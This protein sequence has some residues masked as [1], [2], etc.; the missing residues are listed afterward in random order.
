M[1]PAHMKDF[2]FKQIEGYLSLDQATE[3]LVHVAKCIQ[4]SHKE[5]NAH[6]YDRETQFHV[7]RFRQ[8]SVRVLMD[9]IKFYL[10]QIPEDTT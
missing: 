1:G 10:E 4:S 8:D 9:L 6:N 7:F 5:E 3:S 2:K